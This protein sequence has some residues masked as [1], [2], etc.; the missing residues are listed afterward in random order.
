LPGKEKLTGFMDT[1]TIYTK[2]QE[3]IHS[4]I[5]SGSKF[6]DKERLKRSIQERS[7][8]LHSLFTTDRSEKKFNYFRD[9]FFRYAYIEK[10]LA[11]NACKVTEILSE[12]DD[13]GS[14]QY[15]KDKEEIHVLD[16]GAGPCT[17]LFGFCAWY[18]GRQKLNLVPVD[19]NRSMLAEGKRLFSFHGDSPT[20]KESNQAEVASERLS[21]ISYIECSLSRRGELEKALFPKKFDIIIAANL[22]NELGERRERQGLRLGVLRSLAGSLLGRE[23][24]IIIVEPGTRIA[25]KNLIGLREAFLHS[26]EGESSFRILAPCTHQSPCPLNKRDDNDWCFRSLHGIH[27]DVPV[28]YSYLVIGKGENFRKANSN[29]KRV[30]SDVFSDKDEKVFLTCSSSGK[31]KLRLSEAKKS[32]PTIRR[33]ILIK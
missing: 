24:T 18:K 26:A 11:V 8:V 17:A 32:G 3:R 4:Y 1:K 21:T 22:F 23:G 13:Q 20:E 29:S 10:F 31:Q 19:K 6:K 9:D 7:A 28:G 14:L 27:E 5:Y 16:V 15:L 25:S 33:G 2:L 12:L 30:I